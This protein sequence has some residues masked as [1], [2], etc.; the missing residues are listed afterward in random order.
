MRRI[1]IIAL[2]L[3]LITT[4]LSQVATASGDT[5]AKF[6]KAPIDDKGL[7]TNVK[8]ELSQGGLNVR[9]PF[10]LR[11]F[12]TYFRSSEGAPILSKNDGA[13][14]RANALNDEK[15]TVTW[16]GHATVLVQM[17]G[18]TFLTDPI[19]SDWP[20]PLA[21]IGPR[22]FVEPGIEIDNLPAIDFVVV[23][24]NHYDHLDLPTLKALAQKNADTKFFVPLGNAKLLN[25]QGIAKVTEMDWGD[26]ATY[27]DLTIHCLPTQHW[28]KRSISDTRKTLWS[29][30]AV[31]GP[32]KRFYFAGDTGYFSGFKEIG[33]KLGP[34]NVAAMPI[35]AYE[36]N[37][38]MKASHMD[39]AESI[40]ASLDLKAERVLAIHFGT[41]DLS[42]EPLGEPP[43]LF[44]KAAAA[45]TLAGDKT[46]VFDIGETRE[47]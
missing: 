17:H 2:L 18:V 29:S 7:F 44:R 45:T 42:D 40:M 25:S 28:S 8:G 24:H 37:A 38:M 34:F 11:R 23:S 32:E 14:L 46:W 13:A 30:W 39:P 43:V 36:P 19:W 20:S 31:T 10:M 9:V 12:G 22:R 27:K 4:S 16:V 1:K 15:A 21:Y 6:T 3:T 41:F 26:T 33:E 47:F 5:M 35:G